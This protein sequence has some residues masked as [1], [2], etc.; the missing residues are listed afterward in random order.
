LAKRVSDSDRAASTATLVSVPQT[1]SNSADKLAEMLSQEEGRA[2]NRVALPE[3]LAPPRI[4]IPHAVIVRA[5]GLLPMLY[6]PSE[7]A[8][9]L[10]IPE[11]TLRDWLAKFG[12]PHQRDDSG[13]VWVNGIEFAAWVQQ[14]RQ[15]KKQASLLPNQAYCFRCK[16]PVEMLN[17]Q[18]ASKT[19]KVKLM[20]ATCPQ[21]SGRIYRG[22][23]HDPAQ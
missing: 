15:P 3:P 1:A 2:S 16:Q 14:M 11:R 7:L 12:A 5:P 21:C 10:G 9:D 17:P 8:D 20:A 22:G 13:H 23:C 4:K 6:K 18:P 19:G